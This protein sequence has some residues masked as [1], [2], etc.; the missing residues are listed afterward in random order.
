VNVELS[1]MI[2]EGE[3]QQQ[4][5]KYSINDSRKIAISLV[6]FAN[7]DG[8]RLLLG[9]RDNGSVAGVHS[10]EE[11][12]MVEAAAKLYS[13]PP[14][15]FNFHVWKTEGKNVLEINIEKSGD[16]PH[17]AQDNNGNW[18]AYVRIKDQNIRA[19]KI[20]L[21]VW[22]QEKNPRG[23]HIRF[24]EEEQRILSMLNSEE[25]IG[26]SQLSKRA[27]LSKWKL[28]K[29]LVKLIVVGVVLLENT[30]TGPLFYLNEEDVNNKIKS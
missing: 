13:R 7:T 14:I 10:E 12:Y 28:E 23:V 25:S 17:M 20:L 19:S 8:G 26:L 21:D 22:R 30:E 15:A 18:I 6:A 2:A 16:R 5:F 11:Y 27:K 24:T 3:H 29:L 1:K 4:D 9:I